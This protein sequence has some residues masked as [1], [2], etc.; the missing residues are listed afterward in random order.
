MP[1][2]TVFKITPKSRNLSLSHTNH[3]TG[4]GTEISTPPAP[5]TRGGLASVKRELAECREINS[6]GTYYNVSLFVGGQR[7]TEIYQPMSNR[8]I[9]WQGNGIKSVL[10]IIESYG[11]VMVA[12]IEAETSR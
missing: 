2:E 1:T 4:V 12:T 6:G 3:P 5:K 8:W 9:D 7:V 10:D 11:D